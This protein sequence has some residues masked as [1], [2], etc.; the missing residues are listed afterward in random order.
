MGRERESIGEHYS[1]KGAH[2]LRGQAQNTRNAFNEAFPGVPYFP[3]QQQ[4]SVIDQGLS[5]V[6]Q[7]IIRRSMRRDP[8][9]G[10]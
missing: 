3:A 1:N 8:R 5:K 7:H 6:Q 2:F 9:S 10:R 4:Q